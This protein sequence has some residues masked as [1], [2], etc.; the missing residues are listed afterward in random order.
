[1]RRDK[2]ALFFSRRGAESLLG[3]T[4]EQL[5]ETMLDD[6]AGVADGQ[7]QYFFD[8]NAG[9]IKV[10]IFRAGTWYSATLAEEV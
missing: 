7:A 10:R 2:D 1:M 8:G 6:T 3:N 5:D 9:N 4:V